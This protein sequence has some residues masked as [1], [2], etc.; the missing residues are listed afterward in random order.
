M[1]ERDLLRFLEKISQLQALAKEVD[2]DP[3]RRTELAGHL[4]AWTIVPP[5][6]YLGTK[7]RDT[8]TAKTRL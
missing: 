2:S 1:A 4:F 3:T 5:I 8:N 6:S 7:I